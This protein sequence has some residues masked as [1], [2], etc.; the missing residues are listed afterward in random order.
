MDMAVY[1]D[2]M[3]AKFG[4]M[5]MCHMMADTSREL[6]E[7]AEKIG[8]AHRWIQK[9]GTAYEHFDVSLE[10]RAMAVRAGAIEVTMRDLGMLIRKRKGKSY[11]ATCPTTKDKP[12]PTHR[13]G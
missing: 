1:V 4:R 9:P 3:R 11:D 7:I 2:N 12:A 13:P 6:V 5:I 10:K 8:I